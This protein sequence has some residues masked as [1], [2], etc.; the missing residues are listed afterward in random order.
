MTCVGTPLSLLWWLRF[1]FCI[2]FRPT[3]CC[4]YCPTAVLWFQFRKENCRKFLFIKSCQFRPWVGED[5]PEGEY[6]CS[7]TL[8]LTSALEGMGDERNVPAALPPPPGEGPGTRSIAGWVSHRAG[9]DGCENLAPTG[10][11]SPDRPARSDWAIPAHFIH[12]LYR[13]SVDVSEA[14]VPFNWC[15]K[16]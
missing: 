11:R 14:R 4:S 8:S 15:L 12:K 10:I 1:D 2:T 6:R 13:F 9:L 16:V 5:G 3:C 7:S